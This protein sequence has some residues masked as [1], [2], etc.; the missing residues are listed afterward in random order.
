MTKAELRKKYL[1]KRKQIS[2]GQVQKMS[3]EICN[4]VFTH[5][6]LEGRYVS[7][8]LPIERQNEINTY[9]I[10]EK[11]VK[12][13]A[14]VAV[15]RSNFETTDMKHILFETE[16]QLQLSP[17]GIPEPKKGRVVAADH[18]EIVFVPLLAVDKKGN[19]VGYGKG[20]YDK[21]LKKCS[22][23]CQFIGLHL[24]GLEEKIEDVFEGDIP[25]H[26]CITPEGLIRFE[27]SFQPS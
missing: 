15:P 24:F 25:L 12:F 23:K 19:R 20:F 1:E 16:D 4:L 21:F 13:G 6:Q 14:K 3:E 10:W 27:N 5:F 17:W 26:G 2:P 18:F 7:L 8:F 11:A 9:G 22:P